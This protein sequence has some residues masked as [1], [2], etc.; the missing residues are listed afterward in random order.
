MKGEGGKRQGSKQGSSLAVSR[1]E[2]EGRRK[3]DE[4]KGRAERR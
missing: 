4:E 2:R 1:R 3:E